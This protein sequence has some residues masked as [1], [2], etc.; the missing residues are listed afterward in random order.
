MKMLT[1]KWI[2]ITVPI[3]GILGAIATVIWADDEV[4]LKMVTALGVL[5]VT[6]YVIRWIYEYGSL[7]ARKK[8]TT[9]YEGWERRLVWLFQ[10]HLS[11]SNERGA[12]HKPVHIKL[13]TFDLQGLTGETQKMH[14]RL[15]REMSPPPVEVPDWWIR[16]LP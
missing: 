1:S 10:A 12:N 5:L 9:R 14:E 16:R 11:D 13:D 15:A 6:R 7:M 2:A 8:D 4:R 3:T